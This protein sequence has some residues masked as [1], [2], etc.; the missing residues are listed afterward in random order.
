MTI[1]ELANLAIKISIAFSI[2][3]FGMRATFADGLSLFRQPGLLLRC[4]LSINVVMFFLAVVTVLMFDFHPAIKIGLI[5]LSLSPIPPAIPTKLLK[6]GGSVT[7][8]AGMMI[9][10][11]ALAI[12]I[13][14]LG[15]ALAGEL[16]GKELRMPFVKVAS[17]ILMGVTIPLAIGMT[18]HQFAPALAAR[19]ADRIQFFSSIL[20]ALG[21]FTLLIIVWPIM[22]TLIG[23]GIFIS[24]ALFSIVGLVV[25]H[26]LGGP[27]EI[28][29]T[30]LAIATSTRHPGIVL[31]IAGINFPDEKGVIAVAIFHIVVAGLIALPYIVWRRKVQKR[32][33]I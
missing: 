26:L 19:L 12:V 16:A 24:L 1:L 20:L 3:S 23:H 13:V 7:A 6:A 21:F 27:E 25:G 9:A 22:T 14:P 4:V 5:A 18:I 31:A 33:E 17:T 32:H 28:N 11:S 8:V 29:R 30:M 10:I 15:V 2:I